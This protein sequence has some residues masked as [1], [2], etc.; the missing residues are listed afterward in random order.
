MIDFVKIK[1]KP[2]HYTLRHYDSWD[3]EAHEIGLLKVQMMQ[4][5]GH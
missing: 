3:V 1:I 2:S 5:I 4:I